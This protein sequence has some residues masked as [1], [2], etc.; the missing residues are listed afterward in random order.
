M[1]SDRRGRIEGAPHFAAMPVPQ[2]V[3]CEPSLKRLQLHVSATR[4]YPDTHDDK[5]FTAFE[6][7]TCACGVAATPVVFIGDPSTYAHDR[8][9][10][11]IVTS[12]L[13][14]EEGRGWI[15]ERETA[16]SGMNAQVS[17]MCSPGVLPIC[18]P[19]YGK[20]VVLTCGNKTSAGRCGS[21]QVH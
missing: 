21:F 5:V 6:V 3:T 17:R 18:S 10:V 12:P 11:K 2:I 1:P 8:S 19:N 7:L 9:L 15:R 16:V 13:C 20:D 4:H 14:T